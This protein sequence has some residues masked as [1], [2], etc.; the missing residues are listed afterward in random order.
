MK[1]H[2]LVI[3][4]D[5][6]AL[7]RVTLSKNYLF[8]PPNSPDQTLLP[9]NP[10]YPIITCPVANPADGA[11]YVQT[12]LNQSSQG[13]VY[14][15]DVITGD[16]SA[17][18]YQ[19]EGSNF[20]IDT[21]GNL[22][23][24]IGGR[25]VRFQAPT[26][27]QFV[28]PSTGSP[29]LSAGT[30][31][32]FNSKNNCVYALIFE[33]PNNTYS[34]IASVQ[35]VLKFDAATGAYLGEFIPRVAPGSPSHLVGSYSFCFGP[36]GDLYAAKAFAQGVI[37]FDGS[38]GQFKGEFINP[39]KLNNKWVSNL[40]FSPASLFVSVG[41]WVLEFDLN[42][43]LLGQINPGLP[44]PGAMTIMVEERPS[45]PT[46]PIPHLAFL[47]Q[48]L[49]GVV[50]DNRG[51][52]VIQPHGPRTDPGWNRRVAIGLWHS[53]TNEDRDALVAFGMFELSRLMSHN[54]AGENLRQLMQ[55]KLDKGL[56]HRLQTLIESHRNEWTDSTD[57][58]LRE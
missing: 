37:R 40:V 23:L 44:N 5:S 48:I 17:I 14:R 10:F 22:Y 15:Y 34:L 1:V 38:T 52:S 53:L 26:M 43:N 6:T 33:T 16:M 9:P 25:I 56:L 32:Q 28:F 8:F 57:I 54:G 29:S 7:K 20:S 13:P 21:V 4:F 42:G 58:S 2:S 39:A 12:A 47:T 50:A 19:S 46:P 31:L 27:Q 11:L 41:D 35:A 36:D 30:E 51:V 49:V 55:Q 24:I 45:K 3:A 18:S